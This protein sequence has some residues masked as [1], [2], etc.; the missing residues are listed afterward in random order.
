MGAMKI[1]QQI[2][3]N[4]TNA[5][6][7]KCDLLIWKMRRAK[8]N[9][10]TFIKYPAANEA[11]SL[12]PELPFED[13]SDI[14]AEYIN[15]YKQLSL[16]NSMYVTSNCSLNDRINGRAKKINAHEEEIKGG[17]IPITSDE[18]EIVCM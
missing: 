2:Y 10:P 6:Q 12:N 4:K 8:G 7:K 17:Y 18:L 5:L 11:P 13:Y 15:F 16:W 14:G 3:N 1:T 9:W